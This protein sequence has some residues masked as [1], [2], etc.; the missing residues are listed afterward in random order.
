MPGGYSDG[1]ENSTMRGAL[2]VGLAAESRHCTATSALLCK[3][4][5]K[6]TR[7]AITFTTHAHRLNEQ[8]AAELKGYVHFIRVS[9]DGI[10]TTY[11]SLRGREFHVLCQKDP[12]KNDHGGIKGRHLQLL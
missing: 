11:E 6:T 4:A 9:M 1:Y 10:G 5:A 8:L 7:L 2:A 3:L 12:G